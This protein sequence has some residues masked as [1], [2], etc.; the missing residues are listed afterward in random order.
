MSQWFT[1]EQANVIGAIGGS[2]VGVLGGV[3]GTAAGILVPRGKG[4]PFVVGLFVAMIVCGAVSLLSAIVALATGQPRHVWFPLG[5]VGVI[6]SSIG[7]GLLPMIL[8]RYRQAEQRR[9]EAADL[10]RS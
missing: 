6:A 3:V 4:K 7:A 5:L 1:P 10:R 9:M 2:A 8:G